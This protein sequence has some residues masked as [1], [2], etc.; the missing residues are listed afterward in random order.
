VADYALEVLPEL[1]RSAAVRVLSPPDWTPPA[2]WPREL[3]IVPTD[4]AERR[5]EISLIHLGNN[6]Y[7]LWLLDRLRRTGP[8]VVVLHDA[9]LHHL[10][11][12]STLDLGD[13]AGYARA[14]GAAHGSPGQALAAARSVGIQGRLDPFLF[15]ARRF[16][17][18]SVDAVM[19]HSQWA[20]E[21]IRRELPGI[22]A[23]RV[24]LAVAD[25]RPTDRAAVRKRLGL[26][27]DE[28][29]VMH[30]G[31][32][33]PEK[34]LVEIVT[35]VAA[36][37]ASGLPVRLVVVG[38]GRETETLR[39]AAINAGVGDRLVIAGWVEPADLP[40]FPAAADLGVVYRTPSAGETS[41]AVL[42][43][44]ACSVPVAVGGARQ[45]LEWPEP[46]APRLTPGPPA[47]A[48]LA[49]LLAR[50]GEDGWGD[51]VA[52]ARRCY[53]QSHRPEQAAR[54]MLAFLNTVAVA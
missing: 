10:L 46:A 50:V 34:G 16:F 11:V 51:R 5:G 9:V 23:G 21:L 15:P 44:F 49:R 20:E 27:P 30:L 25:P 54:E 13:Q 37:R 35:G 39:R 43:F 47:A 53:E 36:A 24:G 19:V 18:D 48:D 29:V 6:P 8:T 2:G 22:P 42:R 38:E 14:L 17:L 3:E 32:M 26:Q 40:G 28:V 52:S 41:A 12:A 7:H 33:T 1:A 4:A 31:F 45:F